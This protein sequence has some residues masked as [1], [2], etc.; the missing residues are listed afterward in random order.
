MR[1]SSSALLIG[2]VF[3]IGFGLPADTVGQGLAS[4]V[5]D[6]RA[7]L[8]GLPQEVLR[9]LKKDPSKDS[10]A[11]KLANDKAV[12]NLE[13]KIGTLELKVAEKS[14]QAGMLTLV[15]PDDEIRIGG[16]A[17][18]LYLEILLDPSQRALG[19][20]IKIGSRVKATGTIFAYVIG[21]SKKPTLKLECA[22][23][24]LI[25]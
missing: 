14:E 8:E 17:F 3:V 13:R 9:N 25:P 2:L 4:P 1:L 22:K 7:A 12:A 16:T 10:P 18:A 23:A 15:A 21:G 24:T 5:I 11:V 6:P 19:E 20:K